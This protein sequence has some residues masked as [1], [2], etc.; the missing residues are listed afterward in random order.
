MSKSIWDYTEAK[1]F[2]DDKFNVIFKLCIKNPKKKISLKIQSC[3]YDI[4]KDTVLVK[5]AGE[6]SLYIRPSRIGKVANFGE[7]P[8]KA[9]NVQ[10]S[11]F[12]HFEFKEE[13]IVVNRNCSN[14]ENME[15][16]VKQ[17]PIYFEIIGYV[18]IMRKI[19]IQ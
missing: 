3:N 8:R 4:T 2:Q 18:E 7:F 9:Q 17:Y 11:D 12:Y 14:S 16:P 13:K 1:I 10:I 15:V 6:S 5:I 19:E